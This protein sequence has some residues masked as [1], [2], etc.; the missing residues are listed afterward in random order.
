MFK[1]ILIF[2]I[3]VTVVFTFIQIVKYYNKFMNGIE[4]TFIE[5]LKALIKEK[6]TVYYFIK[7][8][9]GCVMFFIAVIL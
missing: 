7:L 4:G 8:V 1:L 5:R 3:G 2:L 9:Y 6:T